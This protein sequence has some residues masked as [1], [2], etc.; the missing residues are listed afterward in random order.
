VT[1]QDVVSQTANHVGVEQSTAQAVSFIVRIW[2]QSG[3]NEREYRGWV[4]HVQTGRR[5]A[6]HGLDQLRSIIAE[7]VGTSCDRDRSWRRRLERWKT[8]VVERFSREREGEA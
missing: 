4:E 1:E 3:V 6:F 8:F 7:S 5:T 2:L